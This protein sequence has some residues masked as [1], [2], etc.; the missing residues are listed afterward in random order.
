MLRWK[1]FVWPSCNARD[2]KYFISP[3]CHI[4]GQY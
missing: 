2:R 3:P 4:N 1:K